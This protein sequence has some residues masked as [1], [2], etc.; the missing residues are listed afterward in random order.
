VS[1]RK[2]E[3]ALLLVLSY[4]G[5]LG[6]LVLAIDRRDPEVRWHAVHGLVLQVAEIVVS[7]GY[8]VAVGGLAILVPGEVLQ[9][10]KPVL[11]IGLVLLH[12]VAIYDALSGRRLRIPGVSNYADQIAASEP[13][14]A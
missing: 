5:P 1:P 7:L 9:I 3:N 6:I 4:L 8:V 2:G 13:G 10:L 11:Q 12:L 14:A